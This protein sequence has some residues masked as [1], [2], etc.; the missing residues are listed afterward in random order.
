MFKLVDLVVEDP[1]QINQRLSYT[2]TEKLFSDIVQ[3][4]SYMN[5]SHRDTWIKIGSAD[6]NW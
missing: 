4:K 2:E 5:E 6:C 1:S 3:S